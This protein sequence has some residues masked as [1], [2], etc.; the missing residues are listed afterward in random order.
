MM[1]K[2]TPSSA[3]TNGAV[4][5][6][7]KRGDRTVCTAVLNTQTAYK[8]SGTSWIRAVC[9]DEAAAGLDPRYTVDIKNSNVSMSDV[10][11]ER[12]YATKF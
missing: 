8:D 10:F 3:S 7:M 2:A 4:T 6:V 12:I 9:A 1:L 11:A 5:F